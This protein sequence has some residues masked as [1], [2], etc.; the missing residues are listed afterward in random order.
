ML[1]ADGFKMGYFHLD[2]CGFKVMLQFIVRLNGFGGV[3]VSWF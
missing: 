3:R 2:S 1:G